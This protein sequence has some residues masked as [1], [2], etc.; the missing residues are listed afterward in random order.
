MV[1]HS[2]PGGGNSEAKRVSALSETFRLLSDPRRIRALALLRKAEPTT[3][4]ELAAGVAA[5]EPAEMRPGASREGDV[6]PAHAERVALSLHH[7]HLPKLRAAG[8]VE[9]DSGEGTVALGD[10][11]GDAL[12]VLDAVRI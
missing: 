6:S 5:R 4:E 3:I 1:A 11:A 12:D 9:F 10:D 7:A 2:D 8:V